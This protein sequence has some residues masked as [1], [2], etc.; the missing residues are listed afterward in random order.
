MSSL[1]I[2]YF[3]LTIRYL[4]L[5]VKEGEYCSFECNVIIDRTEIWPAKKDDE[6][7]PERN[8]TKMVRWIFYVGPEDRISAVELGNRPQLNAKRK[9]YSGLVA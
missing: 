9:C 2:Y 4:P 3:L 8:D 5:G 6:V 7:K 1:T